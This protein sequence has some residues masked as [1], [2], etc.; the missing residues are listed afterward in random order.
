[1]TQ[2]NGKLEKNGESL[3]DLLYLPGNMETN[4]KLPLILFLHGVDQRG[5][6][7]ELLKNHTL[8]ELI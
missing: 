4:H 6:N 8:P 3:N 7:L 2:R 5:S 1:M